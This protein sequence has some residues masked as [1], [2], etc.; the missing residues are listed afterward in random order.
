M[1]A[2][3]DVVCSALCTVRS[4]L[5]GPG[6]G[7]HACEVVAHDMS[8]NELRVVEGYTLCGLRDSFR[9][10]DTRRVFEGVVYTNP[11]VPQGTS[12]E[13]I[14]AQRHVDV[15]V[16]RLPR[17]CCG[18][19]GEAAMESGRLPLPSSGAMLVIEC[20]D[21]VTYAVHRYYHM[22]KCREL[23]AAGHLLVAR[24]YR[25][26]WPAL[27]SLGDR[28]VSKQRKRGRRAGRKNRRRAIL[29]VASGPIGGR[30]RSRAVQ[31]I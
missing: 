25:R 23:F 29:K 3:S 12:A 22:S 10:R 28:E 19:S 24:V 30:V 31:S 1:K 4:L 5:S 2:G 11:A 18:P 17:G 26:W 6:L 16:W 7:H 13:V 9:V 15:E 27:M 21:L 8:E 14:S 20:V